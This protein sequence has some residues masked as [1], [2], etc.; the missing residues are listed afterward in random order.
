MISTFSFDYIFIDEE[1]QAV[2]RGGEE[3]VRTRVKV[4]VAHEG[5]SG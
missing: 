4:L 1:G 2:K 5:M 3:N